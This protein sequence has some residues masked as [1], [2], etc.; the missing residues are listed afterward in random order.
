MR[1]MIMA[2]EVKNETTNEERKNMTTKQIELNGKEAATVGQGD[3]KLTLWNVNGVERRGKNMETKWMVRDCYG[4]ALQFTGSGRSV[5]C[6]EKDADIFDS[7]AEA[8]D[9]LLRSM[10]FGGEVEAI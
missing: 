8:R 7:Q 3:S 4:H 9:L 1:S 6:D 2:S 10:E 5:Q